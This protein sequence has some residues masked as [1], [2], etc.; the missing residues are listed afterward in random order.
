M[1]GGPKE[2]PHGTSDPPGVSTVEVKPSQELSTSLFLPKTWLQT[3]RL[4]KQ[5]PPQPTHY[6]DAPGTRPK[7]NWETPI[8]IS[9]KILTFPNSCSQKFNN[10]YLCS[11]SCVELPLI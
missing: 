8:F 3:E 1:A 6:L 4:L 7:R 2:T 5:S 11:A 10:I 9:D